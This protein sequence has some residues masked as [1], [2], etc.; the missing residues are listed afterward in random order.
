MRIFERQLLKHCARMG[1]KLALAEQ[2][3]INRDEERDITN[4]EFIDLVE[5]FTD[6]EIGKFFHFDDHE[7]ELIVE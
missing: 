5:D 6:L 3:R 2:E 7:Y 4:I 1:V